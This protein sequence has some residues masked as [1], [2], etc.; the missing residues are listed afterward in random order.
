MREGDSEGE[1]HP[2][3][4]WTLRSETEAL[5]LKTSAGSARAVRV[6][7]LVAPLSADSAGDTP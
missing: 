4:V 6:E 5:D 3:P 7:L 2:T 1:T